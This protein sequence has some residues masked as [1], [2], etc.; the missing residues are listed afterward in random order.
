MSLTRLNASFTPDMVRDA[1]GHE[2]EE[3]ER[4]YFHGD[5]TSKKA[6]YGSLA[7]S[8]KAVSEMP[9]YEKKQA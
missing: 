3:V 6:V 7:E 9:T 4:K 1:V 8:I 5:M 2:Y